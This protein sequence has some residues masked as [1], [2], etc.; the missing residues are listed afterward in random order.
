MLDGLGVLGDRESHAVFVDQI[1]EL[2]RE[3]ATDLYLQRYAEPKDD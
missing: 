1:T 3:V 2:T